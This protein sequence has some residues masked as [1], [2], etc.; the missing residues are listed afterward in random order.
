MLLGAGCGTAEGECCRL[1]AIYCMCSRPTATLR[2]TALG[3]LSWGS[4]RTGERVKHHLP[5][6]VIDAAT[7]A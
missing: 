5:C 4:G 3:S 2:L 7:L 1:M 6:G